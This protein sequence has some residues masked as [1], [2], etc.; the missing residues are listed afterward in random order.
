MGAGLAGSSPCVALL[1]VLQTGC[2]RAA[3]R[4]LQNASTAQAVLRCTGLAPFSI[5]GMA[6]VLLSSED[7]SGPRWCPRWPRAF[8]DRVQQGGCLRQ[9]Q[10]LAQQAPSSSARLFLRCSLPAASCQL[11]GRQH[12]CSKALLTRPPVCSRV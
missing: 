11:D 9:E 2:Q 6:S 5:Q 12:P 8:F 7:Q 4:S 3:V 1:S 10:L